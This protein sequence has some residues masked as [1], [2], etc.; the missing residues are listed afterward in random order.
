[1]PIWGPIPTLIDTLRT[2]NSGFVSLALIR[3]ISSLRRFRD[4][5]SKVGVFCLARRWV[6]SEFLGAAQ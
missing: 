3:A 1:M 5:M 2:S 6:I 4:T